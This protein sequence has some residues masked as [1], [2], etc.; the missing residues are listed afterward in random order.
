[1]HALIRSANSGTTEKNNMASPLMQDI[2]PVRQT[3]GK[4]E[5][6]WLSPKPRTLVSALSRVQLLYSRTRIVFPALMPR[7]FNRTA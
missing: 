5:D 4:D 3:G 6:D 2:Y 1:V 7:N